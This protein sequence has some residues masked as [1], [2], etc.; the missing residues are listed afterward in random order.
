M[1]DLLQNAPLLSGLSAILIAQLLKVLFSFMI[2]R[3]FNWALIF[4]PGR[5]PSSHTAGMS[6]LTTTVGLKDGL[7][8][9]L[10][11]LSLLMT[12]IVMFD[13]AGVRRQ[14]GEHAALLNKLIFEEALTKDEVF[15][16]RAHEQVKRL[17]EIIGHKPSEVMGGLIL[18]VLVGIFWAYYGAV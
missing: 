4:S 15:R 8:S 9:S 14:A 17:K 11:A 7:S 16:T 18:G 5:M 13:A 6:A 10:F 12:A 3:R 2:D 1:L